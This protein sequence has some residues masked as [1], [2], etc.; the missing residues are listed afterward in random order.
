LIRYYTSIN[1]DRYKA[2]KLKF[3]PDPK[4]EAEKSSD[5]TKCDDS[6]HKP[7]IMSFLKAFI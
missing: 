3:F 2:D 7:G 5:N 1:N 4:K 6:C